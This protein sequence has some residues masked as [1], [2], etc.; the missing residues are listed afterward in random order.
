MITNSVDTHSGL[1]I[2][3]ASDY[4]LD[5]DRCPDSKLYSRSRYKI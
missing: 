2:K 5:T 4:G 1:D 3:N